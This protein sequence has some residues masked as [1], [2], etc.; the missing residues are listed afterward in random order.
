MTF[1]TNELTKIA[2]LTSILVIASQ[3]AIQT[4]IGIPFTLQTLIVYFYILNFTRKNTFFS[5]TIYIFLGFLGLPVFSNF[6]NAYSIMNTSL[7]FIIGML[8]ATIVCTTIVRYSQKS[9]M[10]SVLTLCV[11]TFIIYVTGIYYLS[12]FVINIDIRT[13]SP[14]IIMDILKIVIVVIL[15][16]NIHKSHYTK[17]FT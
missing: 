8:I 1:K 13:Y 16:S 15:T 17:L 4:P 6:R 7:G 11:A 5:V 3:L 14:L 2:T 10:N 9:I 12:L